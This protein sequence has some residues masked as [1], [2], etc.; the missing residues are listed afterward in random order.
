MRSVQNSCLD[1]L[2]HKTIIR[3]HESYSLSFGALDDMDTD[4]Y[5]LFSD[6]QL[7]LE[8]ALQKLP[9]VCREAFEMNRLEGLKYREIAEKLN[10]SERTV[11]VRI[12][13]ALALLRN[14]LKE[15]FMAFLLIFGNWK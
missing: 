4:N 1:E 7:H 6:L 11:E 14:H 12:G 10:V 8:V 9:V 15:F 5:V 3:E 13:K 2:R